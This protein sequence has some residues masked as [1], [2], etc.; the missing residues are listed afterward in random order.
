MDI[1]QKTNT[2]I[3]PPE[4]ERTSVYDEFGQLLSNERGVEVTEL[5]WKIIGEAFKYSNEKSASIPSDTSLMDFFNIKIKE[6]ELDGVTSKL[7]LQMAHVWGDYVG[8]SIAKQSLKY[9]W[10]E[11]CLDE[12]MLPLL[13]PLRSMFLTR[14]R[15]PL[16]SRHI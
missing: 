14:Q 2:T 5:V 12:S 7:V 8:E 13:P 10:L 6:W 9:I 15:E 1:A 3:F 11:E 16:R 4:F